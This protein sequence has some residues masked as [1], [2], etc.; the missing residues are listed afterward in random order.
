MKLN[1]KK[2]RIM[3]NEVAKRQ[4][5]QGITIDGEKLEEVNEYK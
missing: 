4:Q 2:T 5:K 3:C 1:K